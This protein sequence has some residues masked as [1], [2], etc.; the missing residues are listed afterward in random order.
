MSELS[1]SIA[2]H[3]LSLAIPSKMVWSTTFVAGSWARTSSKSTARGKST[4]ESSSSGTSSTA[5]TWDRVGTRWTWARPLYLISRHS[6][7]SQYLHSQPNVLV[8]HSYSNDRLYQHRS[9][10]GLGSLPGHDLGPGNGSTAWPQLFL[11][12]GIHSTH[13]LLAVNFNLW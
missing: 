12:M 13:V 5:S 3:S 10:E 2:F 6:L 8:D 1:T 11:A 4:T 7:S 9:G